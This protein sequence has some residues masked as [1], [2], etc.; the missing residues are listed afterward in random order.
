MAIGIYHQNKRLLTKR[1]VWCEG[2]EFTH[3]SENC[4]HSKRG[5]FDFNRTYYNALDIAIFE[6][7]HL[8]CTLWYR[9]F[10]EDLGFA[11]VRLSECIFFWPRIL[12]LYRVTKYDASP[13]LGKRGS[14]FFNRKYF[15][16]RILLCIL[17]LQLLTLIQFT[18]FTKLLHRS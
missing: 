14:H 17:Q 6:F 3:K 2:D 5:L 9:G 16:E 4:V 12:S 8:F 7:K 11:Y 13:L 15:N 18:L 1:P 10:D